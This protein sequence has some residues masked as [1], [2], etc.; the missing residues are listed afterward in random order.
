MVSV[1]IITVG[2]LETNCYLV[3]EGKDCLVVDPGDEAETIL[4][5]LGNRRVLAVVATHLHFDHIGA[6]EGIVSS[7]GA[8]FMVH[9]LD[10]EM[11]DKYTQLARSWGFEPPNLPQ[12]IFI[13]EGSGL[14]FNLKVMHTPG[15]TPGSI[16][17]VGDGFVLTGDTLF[18]GSVGRTDLP[19][20]DIELLIRS[21]C[22]L[23]REL[24]GNYIVYPGHG[25]PTTINDEADN[26][27]FV[28]KSLCT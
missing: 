26:N 6:V 5:I 7:T 4:T 9:R 19:G 23:Y 25:P 28:P 16:S 10:W 3:C 20:G 12:P 1:E 8:P 24:P 2:P 17:I 13:D 27:Y 14:P 18:A 15:H 22:R 11:R 21:I